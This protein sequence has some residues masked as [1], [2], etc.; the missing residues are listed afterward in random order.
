[1]CYVLDSHW[2]VCVT[3]LCSENWQKATTAYKLLSE[4]DEWDQWHWKVC[5]RKQSP[6]T[7][8]AWP[9][10]S[11]LPGFPPTHLHLHARHM[12]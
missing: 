6:E 4:V 1:M 11:E 8:H 7:E 10:H 12:S 2:I 3:F 5:G 9:Q